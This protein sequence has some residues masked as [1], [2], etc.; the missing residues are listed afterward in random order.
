MV[1]LP[2]TV[3]SPPVFPMPV[4]TCPGRTSPQ[5]GTHG[6]VFIHTGYSPLLFLQLENSSP[7]LSMVINYEAAT[8]IQQRSNLSRLHFNN[9]PVLL[10]WSLFLC[11][12]PV[13]CT[14]CPMI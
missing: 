4:F 8:C 3:G 5:H 13:K 9:S 2:A 12:P 1:G 7:F 10:L 6:P 14:I 11:F